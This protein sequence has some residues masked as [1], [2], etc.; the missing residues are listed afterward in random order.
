MVQVTFFVSKCKRLFVSL[1]Y[2]RGF[3]LPLQP[4]SPCAKSGMLCLG[5][6]FAY[7]EV[8]CRGEPKKNHKKKNPGALIMH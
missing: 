3:I 8:C 7:A 6:G 5:A 2:R 1:V 4:F